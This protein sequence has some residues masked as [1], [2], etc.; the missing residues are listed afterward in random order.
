MKQVRAGLNSYNRN[1]WAAAYGL[2]L[3]GGSRGLEIQASGG[4]PESQTT[5]HGMIAE[6]VWENTTAQAAVL[7]EEIEKAERRKH[8]WTASDDSIGTWNQQPATSWLPPFSNPQTQ[9]QP[10]HLGRHRRH[11]IL[12]EPLADLPSQRR[13]VRHQRHGQSH[14]HHQQRRQLGGKQA[15]RHGLAE[16]NEGKLACREQ[17]TCSVLSQVPNFMRTGAQR[18]TRLAGNKRC[19]NSDQVPSFKQT[20]AQSRQSRPT[21]SFLRMLQ[22]IAAHCSTRPILGR[23]GLAIDQTALPPE[24]SIERFG[25]SNYFICPEGNITGAALFNNRTALASS[26]YRSRV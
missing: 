14:H 10:P 24:A 6:D 18:R 2:G 3:L 11:V 17:Q 16:S 7:R 1:L 9:S 21:K 22:A 25:R 15:L 23:R 12:L 20:G 13:Q 8:G 26:M 5:A 19:S 4:A